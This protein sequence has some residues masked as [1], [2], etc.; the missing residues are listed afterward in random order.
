LKDVRNELGWIKRQPSFSSAGDVLRN[1]T[2]GQ[3]L[4]SDCADDLRRPFGQSCAF[5]SPLKRIPPAIKFLSRPQQDPYAVKKASGEWL[6]AIK[7][8]DQK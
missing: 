6:E 4:P 3:F 8:P 1:L 5:V 2:C 7:K